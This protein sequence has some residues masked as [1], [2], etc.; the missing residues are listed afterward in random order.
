MTERWGGAKKMIFSVPYTDIKILTIIDEQGMR[1]AIYNPYK[2]TMPIPWL[3]KCPHCRMGEQED[4]SL[5]IRKLIQV[6][7]TAKPDGPDGYGFTLPNKY[8]IGTRRDSKG[9]GVRVKKPR[10]SSSLYVVKL[11]GTKPTG[12]QES[13]RDFRSPVLLRTLKLLFS[14]KEATESEVQAVLLPM[15]KQPLSDLPIEQQ[16]PCRQ[17]IHPRAKQL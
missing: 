9:W 2:L 13:A 4:I 5:K 15:R 10:S 6:L 3:D 11:D 1:G 12:L 17:A 16:T 14:A 7:C 8:K